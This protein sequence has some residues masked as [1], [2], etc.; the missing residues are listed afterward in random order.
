MTRLSSPDVTRQHWRHVTWYGSKRLIPPSSSIF[1]PGFPINFQAISQV[2]SQV[3]P[4]FFQIF[5]RFAAD[6]Q[7]PR[8]RAGPSGP[9]WAAW[10][11]LWCAPRFCP[12]KS[13]GK[14]PD[15]DEKPTALRRVLIQSPKEVK[16]VWM[17]NSQVSWWMLMA[18]CEPHML[19]R[20]TKS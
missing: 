3:F 13:M 5:P 12:G 18:C 8:Q 20:K 7:I 17:V 10:A 4:D 14:A 11:S 2:I 19:R 9:W 6:P 1:F 16:Q 15:V